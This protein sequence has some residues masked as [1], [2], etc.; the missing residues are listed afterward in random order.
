MNDDEKG[1]TKISSSD[2]SK[3]REE[4]QAED[5]AGT[6]DKDASGKIEKGITGVYEIFN[7][8]SGKRYVG[9]SSWC[10][11]RRWDGHRNQLRR[12]VHHSILLQR[13]WNKY[14][15]YE[16][17]FNILLKCSPETCIEN[18]QKFINELNACSPLFGYNIR[19]VAGSPR[20]LK[21]SETSRNKISES[22]KTYFSNP[23]ERQ[24]LTDQMKK[25]WSNP[26]LRERMAKAIREGQD[27]PEIRLKMRNS[28]NRIWAD[29]VK[30]KE[31]SERAKRQFGTPEAKAAA[32]K[33][34]KALWLTAKHR[35]KMSKRPKGEQNGKS[36]LTVEKVKWVR[37]QYSNKMKMNKIAQMLGLN[38]TTIRDI[39]IGKTW[40]H[41]C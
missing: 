4:I 15:E 31:Q 5:H 23:L 21:L 24:R 34:H 11:Q 26:C 14:G 17:E 7:F 29:P 40:K 33:S 1:N 10:V 30:R 9:S 22:L 39:I 32:S 20:G 2:R 41:V 36:K 6:A 3:R 18:E 35:E 16:F 8:R 27:K 12:G 38:S 13:A 25:A 37:V 19:P 28:Q